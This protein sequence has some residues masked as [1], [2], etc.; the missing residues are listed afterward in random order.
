MQVLTLFCIQIIPGGENQ[1]VES[2]AWAHQTKVLDVD[3]YE[4]PGELA[5]AE[6]ALLETRPRL[7]SAGL[8]GNIVEWDTTTLTPMVSVFIHTQDREH[9]LTAFVNS[10]LKNP[11]PELFGVSM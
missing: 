2:L 11:V 9:T 7:F 4:T 3:E 10:V 6:Q 1:A 8:N 5:E